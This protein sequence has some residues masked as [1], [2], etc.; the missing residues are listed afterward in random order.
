MR[1]APVTARQGLNHAGE[2]IDL[3]TLRQ[4]LQAFTRQVRA[5]SDYATTPAWAKMLAQ[6]KNMLPN[7]WPLRW[8]SPPRKV[9]GPFNRNGPT[10]LWSGS[11]GASNAGAARKPATQWWDAL[12]AR[13]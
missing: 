1:I 5:R 13:C 2:A 7:S 12:C 10:I 6:I 3:P 4:H 8:W 9:R 11:F